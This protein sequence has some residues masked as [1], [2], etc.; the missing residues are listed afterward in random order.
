ML[1]ES[2][3]QLADYPGAETLFPA[4]IEDKRFSQQSLFRLAQIERSRGNEQNA[5]KYFKR[6]VEEG[7][8]SLWKGYAERELEFARLNNSIKTLIDG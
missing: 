5:L 6:I 3:F 4:L 7:D 8:D 1:A 2:R